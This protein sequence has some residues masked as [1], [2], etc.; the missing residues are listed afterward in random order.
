ML[1]E[2]TDRLGSSNAG[3]KELREFV[4]GLLSKEHVVHGC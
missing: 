4:L 1:R 2:A 3:S